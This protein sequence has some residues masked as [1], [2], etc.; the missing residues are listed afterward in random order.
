MT[1]TE[2]G[3]D[4]VLDADPGSMW[5]DG[6]TAGHA[7]GL[8]ARPPAT[9]CVAVPIRWRH[10]HA[11]DTFRAG[12]GDLWH[13]ASVTPRPAGLV[14]VVAR[15]GTRE[16]GVDLDP[17][18]TVAVLYEVAEADAITCAVH[19]LGARLIERRGGAS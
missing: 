14:R 18:D 16:H 4:L 17:D 11:G 8:A 10:A 3:V 7:A 2:P 12:N 1:T 15:H 13:V 5:H 19:E 6:Y 9:A